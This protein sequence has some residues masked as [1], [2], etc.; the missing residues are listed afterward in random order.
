METLVVGRGE[1]WWGETP[2]EKG[3]PFLVVSRNSA[4]A[5]MQK[6]LV[7]PITTR[8][9]SVP[10]E[11]PLGVADG[12][13]HQCVAS[14]DNLQPMP[15]AMLTRRLGAVEATRTHL[16]CDVAAATLAC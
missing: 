6:V 2:D 1:I 11:L 7:A 12:L 8:V 3:R 10:S 16:L 13:P 14:F 9:R 15:K 5:V 4:N